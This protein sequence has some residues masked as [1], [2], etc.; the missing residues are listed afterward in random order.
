MNEVVK[1]KKVRFTRKIISIFLSV[2]IFVLSFAPA[3]SAV[4]Y[5]AGVTPEQAQTA[6]E[7]TDVVLNAALN[8]AE[9]KGLA[10]LL[11]P[12]L[13]CDETLSSL[14][15]MMYSAVEENAETFSTIGIGIT[16]ADVAKNLTNY[17]D[18]QSRLMYCVSWSEVNLTGAEWGVSTTGQFTDAV[19]ALLLPMN[20]LLYT[21]LC[22]GSYSLN[23]LVGIQGSKGYETAVVQIFNRFGMQSY[24]DPS[25]FYSSA[26]SDRTTMIRNLINDIVAYLELVCSAPASMLSK[27]LPG[28]ADFIENG[29]LDSAVQKLVEPLKIK[30]LGIT[31][32]IK[33][34]NIMESAQQ[35]E[36]GM[37]FDINIDIG[38]F[39]ATGTLV[40]APFDMQEI[41]SF[42]TETPEGYSVNT[43][44]SFIYIFRWMLETVRLNMGSI[45]QMISGLTPEMDAAKIS[46]LL[47]GL[48]SNGT[49]ELISVY[50]GLLTA[51]SG[52]V[53]PY[54]WYFNAV[55]PYAVTYTPNLTAEKFQRILTGK[56]SVDVLISQFVKESGEGENLRAV[57]APEIYSNTLVTK[58]VSGIYSMLSDEQLKTFLS[59]AG[60]D[61]SPAAL[62][63]RLSEDAYG[64]A[65]DA[66]L[67]V[68]DYSELEAIEVNW[69][70]KNGNRD[71]FIRA[72][73]ACFRPLEG[74]IRMI[75]CG[76]SLNVLG[77]VPFYGSDGYNTAVIPILE[78]LGCS[79]GEIHAFDEYNKLVRQTDVMLPIVQSVVSLVERII[80]APV[81]TVTGILP[82]LMYFLNNGGLDI[83]INNLLYPVV[84]IMDSLGLS[85]QF[86][87]S[88]LMQLDTDKIMADL[89]GGL[90]LGVKLP[91]LDLQQF[92]YMGTLVPAQTRRTQLTQPMTIQYLQADQAAVLV[93]LFRYLV[94]IMKTPGNEGIVDSF[95]ATNG[96]NELFA[97]YSSDIGSQ[98]A[99]MSVDE[100]I[101]WLY[102][103]FFR[104][105]ATVQENNLE[106][107]TP[108]IIYKEEKDINWW[109]V[110]GVTVAVAA[111]GVAIAY[112][113]RKKLFELIERLKEKKAEE[114]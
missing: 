30:I 31:T 83:C 41:A 95:M 80:D 6:M 3:A 104:E 61:V 48:F 70:F 38:S 54:Q 75:L 96:D 77:A 16:P 46:Q 56:D 76:D 26:A 52:K 21:L 114:E 29:G 10:A 50:I 35:G 36:E 17:P 73:S 34:G 106:D 64:K 9:G 100:T 101:E 109:A 57:I 102:K 33:I 86:D 88:A 111:V 47:T 93:T 62:A 97:N 45:P 108:T 2:M 19:V 22:G 92:G 60:I 71:G 72:V 40:T 91:E 15:K 84:S 8:A 12:M 113:N 85:G 99:A 69:G 105:R 68:N 66:L 43:S 14:A 24:T 58:L 28:I 13:L 18:V 87:F 74:L 4:S 5:P 90:D 103:I 37:S 59:L 11:I 49:D 67:S 94:Q 23:P 53:N 79:Y 25:V 44:D 63:S 65:R 55:A 89:M 7:K 39:T 112:I 20:E 78:A 98:L 32:P 81:Y 27:N 42:I 82:N 110:L 107:Y 51:Q 1:L